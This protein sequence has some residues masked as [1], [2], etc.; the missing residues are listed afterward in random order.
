M[1]TELVVAFTQ[2]DQ[3]HQLLECQQQWQH[4]QQQRQQLQWRLPLILEGEVTMNK[5][6]N[7]SRSLCGTL[8]KEN[9]T[10]CAQAQ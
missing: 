10:L 5:G 8:V 9:A 1:S 3:R 7:E 4:E 2:C 6:E